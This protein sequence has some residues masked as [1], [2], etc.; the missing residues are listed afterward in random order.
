MTA[1]VDAASISL[2]VRELQKAT[3]VLIC[4]QCAAE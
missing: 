3:A 4:I 2:E 1:A